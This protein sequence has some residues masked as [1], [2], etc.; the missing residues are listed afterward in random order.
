VNVYVYNP[1]CECDWCLN[2]GNVPEGTPSNGH[3]FGYDVPHIPPRMNL[4]DQT[5]VIG[6]APE[7]RRFFDT[8]EQGLEPEIHPTARV[9]AYVTVD[10]GADHPTRVGANTWLMKKS[11]VGHDAQ[12][13][14]DCDIAPL[15]N[16]GGYA[17]VGDGVK[18]GMSAV[19]LPY[20]TVG[21]GARIGAGSVVTKD[22]PAGAT[23][24]GNP[25][26]KLEDEDR[27]PRPHD[28]RTARTLQP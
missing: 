22:V 19:I 21:D 28:Q 16:I 11:H 14:R 9:E 3:S 25:A 8:R 4:R 27:D 7:H 24:A 10:S 17:I 13:G 23:W 20:R 26:R 1:S 12:V 2:D 15:A 6:H 5:A 18:I